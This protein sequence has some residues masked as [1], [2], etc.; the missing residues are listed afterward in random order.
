MK[1]ILFAAFFML[2][3]KVGHKNKMDKN[4]QRDG[5]WVEKYS[6]G[7]IKSETV[8]RNGVIIN[9][10]KSY[11]ENG[12]IETL[13][14]YSDS[15]RNGDQFIY[16]PNGTVQMHS[17]YFKGKCLFHKEFANSGTSSVE[18][19]FYESGKLKA[20][21]IVENGDTVLLTKH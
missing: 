9:Y 19:Y 15:I 3:T 10:F 5:P 17:F 13:Y 21:V 8:Y 12:K 18:D 4:G 1:M 14:N 7:K 16:Y 20:S 6:S 11:Y 2:F